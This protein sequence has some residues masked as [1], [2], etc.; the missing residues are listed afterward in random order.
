MTVE[1]KLLGTGAGPGVPSYFCDCP[2]CKEAREN[3]C[4]ARTRSG[5]VIDTGKEKILIDASPDLRSQLVR[6]QITSLDY[7]FLTHWHYDHFG[8]LGDLEFYVK[9]SRRQPLKLFLPPEALEAFHSAYP[10]L[11]EVFDLITWQFEQVYCFENLTLTPLPARHGIQTAGLVLESK[12]K[13]AYFTD[14][15]GL[16]DSTARIIEGTDFLVCD[17]TFYGENWYPHRHMSLEE[18]IQLGKKVKAG[19]TVLTHLAMHYST[20][21]TVAQLAEEISAHPGVSLAYDGMVIT[22]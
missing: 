4:L 9:L 3:P 10:F 20:P 1:F 19:N 16:P 22:L 11:P 7:V 12:R 18:A 8:G 5:A 17:A 21:V 15:S 2:A 14:T 6:E 13:L